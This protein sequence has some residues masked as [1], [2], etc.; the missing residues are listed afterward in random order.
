[1]SNIVFPTLKGLGWDLK[2]KDEFFSLS[3]KG[4]TPGFETRVLLGPDP[5]I[6]FDLTYSYL[7]QKTY[8]STP[9]YQNST[10]EIAT[11]R[12]F[13]RARNGDFDSFLVSLPAL[14][15][16]PA[17]GATT[18]QVLT[19][20]SNNVAPLVVIRETYTENIYEAFGI[21]G[22]PGTAPV[23]KKNG[24]PLVSVTDYNFVGPGFALAGVTYPG[25]A[26]QFITATAGQT[27]TV[28]F[29]WYYRVRFEQSDQEFDLFLALLY[30][31]QKVQFITTRT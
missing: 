2:I 6:H 5:I 7:R 16:N 31:A 26:I 17:D 19:P 11:L 14:S 10:D 4:T 25:L 28:D 9:G 18:G 21:N 30:S 3:Q 1:M 20:D 29:N 23:V 15:L 12:G 27:M 8:S 13:F 22:N 24:T